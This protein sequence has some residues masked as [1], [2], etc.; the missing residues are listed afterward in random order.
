MTEQPTATAFERVLVELAESRGLK[1]LEE[2]KDK[3]RA[4]GHAQTARSLPEEAPGGFG[5]GLHDV[6]D[7]SEKEKVLVANAF[8]ATFLST[9]C[10][11]PGCERPLDP[12]TGSFRGCTEHRAE[13][14][15]CAEEDAWEYAQSILMPLLQATRQIG[16]DELTGVMEEALEEV[17]ENLARARARHERAEAALEPAGAPRV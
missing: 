9:R 12:Y 15:A 3:L 16:S 11:A 6:L 2:L 14:D 4:A 1:D 8:S 7:L 17:N 13:Y 5:E 10:G